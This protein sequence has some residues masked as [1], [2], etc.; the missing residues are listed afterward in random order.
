MHSKHSANARGRSSASCECLLHVKR[1]S[2]YKI[3]NGIHPL[4]P[5]WANLL[6]RSCLTKPKTFS[7]SLFIEQEHVLL[8]MSSH[9]MPSHVK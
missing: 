2:L 8:A 9:V 3:N 7:K 4:A 1:R 5:H 6:K